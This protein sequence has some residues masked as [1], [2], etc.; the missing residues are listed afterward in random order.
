MQQLRDYQSRACRQTREQWEAGHNSVC[1]VCPTGGGKTTIGAELCCDFRH[2]VWVA[3]RKELITQA[4]ERLREFGLDVGIIMP[5]HPRT[6]APIQVGTVQT[7]L[8]RDIRPPADLVVLDECHHYALASEHWSSFLDAYAIAAPVPFHE[9]DIGGTKLLG[10]TATPERRD[11]SP[12]GDI[13]TAL[14]VAASYSEL[15]AAGHLAPCVV[16][17]PPPDK[18]SAG[19]SCD[20]VMAYQKYAPG[21]IAFAFFDRVAR[22]NEWER[23]FSLAGI[24]ARTI[25][26]KTPDRDRAD[27]LE[28]FARGNPRIVCNVA[29]MTEGVDVP[30]AAT[31]ILGRCPEHPSTFLQ[32]VGRVLRPH[33]G[34]PHA[35]LLDISDA[36]SRHGYPTEDREYSLTGQAITRASKSEVRRCAECMAMYPSKLPAC[37]MCGWVPPKPKPIE[38]RIYAAELARVYAGAD[39]PDE[40]K[41]AEFQRLIELAKRKGWALYFV[42]KEY[43]KLFADEPPQQWL[44]ALPEDIRLAEYHSLK[45]AQLTRGFKP[46]FV[47]ARYKAM[48]GVWPPREWSAL[49][50]KRREAQEDQSWP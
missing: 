36:T 2:V 41:L 44:R 11:G 7:L 30:A 32:M 21:T 20:P 49:P 47:P 38:V 17:A 6:D 28:G 31:C 43:K 46:G 25:D 35:L 40:H 45:L 42:V 1:L 18:A 37:P 34:K 13:F 22:S 8:A 27:I 29:T 48:F 23:A 5:G 3:H 24:Q 12:L 4:A 10:L 15:L 14:V 33:P 26:G 39:T 9:N 19:W 50:V 16:Y